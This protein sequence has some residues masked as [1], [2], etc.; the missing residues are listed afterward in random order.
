MDVGPEGIRLHE[1]VL[2]AGQIKALRTAEAQDA[3]WLLVGGFWIV[4]CKAFAEVLRAHASKVNPIGRVDWIDLGSF[5]AFV[6]M[7]IAVWQYQL[8]RAR[9]IRNGRI[10]Y[11]ML[12]KHLK[13]ELFYDGRSKSL[14]KR[15]TWRIPWRQVSGAVDKTDH[16]EFC[17]ASPRP[18]VVPAACFDNEEQKALFEKLAL[19]R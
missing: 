13:M 5:V 3:V 10:Q 2:S 8:S 15:G 19:R 12:P 4:A 17:P 7:V 18:H 14:V 9:S 1:V 11:T 16:L 6:L